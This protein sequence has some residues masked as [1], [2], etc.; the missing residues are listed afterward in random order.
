VKDRETAKIG[1][2]GNKMQNTLAEIVFCKTSI[3]INLLE[4]QPKAIRLCGAVCVKILND[5]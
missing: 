3:V 1:I 2:I 5:H 4:F